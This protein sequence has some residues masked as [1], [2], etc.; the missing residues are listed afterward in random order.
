[1]EKNI[2]IK[3]SDGIVVGVYT[4]DPDYNVHIVDADDF[5]VNGLDPLVAQYYQDVEEI[6]EELYEIA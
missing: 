4:P 2:V 5:P 3:V 1:M 6:C